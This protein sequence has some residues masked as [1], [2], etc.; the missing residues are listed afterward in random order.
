VHGS[1]H[2]GFVIEL[3]KLATLR[4]GTENP[5][6]EF[7]PTA[8][9]LALSSAA[10]EK[11]RRK[12]ILAANL[13]LGLDFAAVGTAVNQNDDFAFRNVRFR[14]GFVGVVIH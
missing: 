4:I 14:H 1:C 6:R 11:P 8:S 7:A 10:W 9:V 12:S 5:G 13:A 2:K 3:K